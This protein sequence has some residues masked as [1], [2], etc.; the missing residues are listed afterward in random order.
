[1]YEPCRFSSITQ[2]GNQMCCYLVV[3]GKAVRTSVQTGVSNGTMIEVTEKLVQSAGSTKGT[4]QPFD[5]NE[6][7]IEGDLSE[8]SD[9]KAV[10][11][12]GGS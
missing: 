9:G 4:W 10:K 6:L 1:M 8:I 2:I 7:V 12:D 5:G 3:N 11:V